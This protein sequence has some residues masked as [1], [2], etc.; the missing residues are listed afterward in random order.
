KSEP[1][2]AQLRGASATGIDFDGPGREIR[3]VDPSD[4]V[5]TRRRQANRGGVDAGDLSIHRSK[6]VRGERLNQIDRSSRGGGR[7][8]DADAWRARHLKGQCGDDSD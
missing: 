6:L 1:D 4:A 5:T 7:R 8:W 2:V 3:P